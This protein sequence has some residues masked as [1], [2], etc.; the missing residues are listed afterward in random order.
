MSLANALERELFEVQNQLRT[1]P[2]NYLWYLLDPV[3]QQ[4]I[5]DAYPDVTDEQAFTNAHAALEG[6][7]ASSMGGYPL[8]VLEWSDGIAL[9]ARDHCASGR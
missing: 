3:K 1:N 5:K 8:D 2:E 7:V 6:L 9:A 4:L